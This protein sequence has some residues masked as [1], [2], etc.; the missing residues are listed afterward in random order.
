[1]SSVPN[2]VLNN[3]VEIPQLGFGVFKVPPEETR[4]AVLT[5]LETG[6]RHIDTARLYD[7]EAAVGAAVRDSDL[8]RDEI[9]VTTKVW[10]TDQGY[11]ATLRAFDA[12]M[13]R[14]GLDVLDLYLIHWPAPARD[15]YV[16]TWRAM[17]QLYRDGRVRA[18][19]VS[20]FQPDHLRRLLDRCDVVPVINQVELHPYLQQNEARK[21]HEEL[22]VLTE[23]WA[24]I[25]RGG[26]LLEDPVITALADKHAR[27]PAQVVLRWHIELGNVVIPKSVTPARV[28]ENFSIFDFTLDGADLAEIAALDRGERTGPD[29][30]RLNT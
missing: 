20:N 27:T 16:D 30:D 25:A 1:M 6:Y 23:A 15:L 21:A 19:G 4:Q 29:P 7:N 12:S 26:A 8:M 3:G 11:D 22:G 24:P 9:F 13:E 14:L 18:I 5:A 2:L 17:E 10:N 28:A